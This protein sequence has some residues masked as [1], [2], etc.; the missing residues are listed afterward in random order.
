[1]FSHYD[2]LWIHES[3]FWQWGGSRAGGGRHSELAQ[4]LDDPVRIGDA[5]GL[6]FGIGQS[7]VDPDVEGASG[8][9]FQGDVGAQ[10]AA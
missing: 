1:M 6:G 7:A 10:F 5:P 8:P 2:K 9:G 3:F 4:Q